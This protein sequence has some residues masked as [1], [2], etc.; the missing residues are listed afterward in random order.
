MRHFHL[1]IYFPLLVLLATLSAC[2]GEE[3]SRPS[4]E[5]VGYLRL[6]L[7]DIS[8]AVSGEV[9]T[10]AGTLTLPS[11][12]M[13]VKTDF[14]IDIKQG[15]ASLE[16]YPKPYSEID[17]QAL[18]LSTGIYTI[19]AYAGTNEL[20][21][22][23]PYFYGSKEVRIVPGESLEESIETSLAN[24]M[25]VAAVSENL[26]KHYKTWQLTVNV[27]EDSNVLATHEVSGG[28][29]FVRSGQM[30]K[31]LFEGK[32]LLDNQTSKEWDLIDQAEARKQYIVQCDPDLSIFS[33]IE[34]QAV[35]IPTYDE[36]GMLTG[37]KITLG[38]VAE[39]VPIELVDTWTVSALYNDTPIR[40][41]SGNNLT[42]TMTVV[43][44]W[45][46][47]PKGSKLVTSIKL[48]TGEE[49]ELSP[50]DITITEPNFS[51]SVSGRTSYSVYA[52]EHDVAA[53]NAMD[54]S[55]IVDIV[56]MASIVEGILNNPNYSG[57]LKSSYKTDTGQES[58]EF[59]YGAKASFT[60]L[61]WQK[62]SLTATVTFDGTEKVSTPI[63]CHVTGLPYR[64]EPPKQEEW[65]GEGKL[66]WES[67][68]VQL[69]KNATSNPQS[70]L[71]NKFYVPKE[72][73]VEIDTKYHVQGATSGTTFS[74]FIGTNELFRTTVAGAT[75][76]NPNS[77]TVEEKRFSVL[78]SSNNYIKCN[79]SYGL[80][81]THSIVY[82]INVYYSIEQ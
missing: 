3:L 62:H 18:E 40:T 41:Y 51:V 79:N 45:P 52:D 59:A 19:E 2:V 81:Q 5:G 22:E 64:A 7:G 25:L 56:A 78:S 38:C 13:P 42:G 61:A 10:K 12:Y 35:A 46:Y 1:F 70:I 54:G 47:V 72:L 76:F 66:S 29:L 69:G 14:M 43:E 23:K 36:G 77:E 68:Y 11:T 28:T 30:V 27:E 48:R 31:A 37:S 53:A 80:G 67:G 82:K 21:Q 60:S 26:R 75:I 39:G 50:A 49:F 20:I 44:G 63:D 16:G 17:G 8:A 15:G 73:N 6:T 57:L 4:G 65:T 58:E 32:N 74:L 71:F 33:K 55:S 24:T 34:M 9:E